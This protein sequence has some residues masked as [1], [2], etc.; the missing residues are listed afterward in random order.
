MKT[1]DLIRGLSSDR[2]TGMAMG[3]AWTLALALAIVAAGAVFFATMGPRPDFGAAAET[4]R[5]VFKFFVTGALAATAWLTVK[6]LS[7]PGGG[8]RAL[9]PLL[10]APAML[11]AAVLIELSVIPPDQIGMRLVG[12]NAAICLVAIPAIGLLPLAIFFAALRHGAPDRP[13]LA[14]LVAGIL[15]GGVA[16]SFYAAHCTDDSP[17]FVIVWYS[18]AIAVLGVAGALAGRMAARW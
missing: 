5:F 10:V 1:D 16:A 18:L 3:R 11:I 12:K 8:E 9:L 6:R 2:A 13:Q 17:L 15:A 4:S 7:T 14:G